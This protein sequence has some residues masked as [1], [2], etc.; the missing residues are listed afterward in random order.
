MCIVCSLD[1]L[2]H[3]ALGV[4]VAALLAGRDGTRL[5]LVHGASPRSVKEGLDACTAYAAQCSSAVRL[6]MTAEQGLGALAEVAERVDASTVV[7]T[8]PASLTH[9]WCNEVVG[10]LLARSMRP[11]LLARELLPFEGWAKGV[12]PLCAVMDADF[13]LATRRGAQWVE[14]L[15]LRGPCELVAVHH[16]ESIQA[17]DA[18]CGLAANSP[19]EATAST[20]LEREL[21]SSLGLLRGDLSLRVRPVPVSARGRA[22]IAHRAVEEGADLLVLPVEL[23][24]GRSQAFAGSLLQA[25]REVR[26]SVLCMPRPSALDLN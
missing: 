9:G 12:R 25:L 20:S 24:A 3:A 11:V 6:H 22:S 4:R 21:T 1:P 18:R 15:A 16:Y 10:K 7:L 23:R 13:D 5:H 26:C 14:Q 8:V 19:V 2:E 17:A